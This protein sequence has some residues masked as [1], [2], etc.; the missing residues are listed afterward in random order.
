[1]DI[2]K[3]DILVIKVKYKILATNA[4]GIIAVFVNVPELS[5]MY[6]YNT[7]I[8]TPEL[9]EINTKL[10]IGSLMPKMM[11]ANDEYTVM[12]DTVSKM[13]DRLGM[14]L[15]GKLISTIIE[16]LEKKDTGSVEFHFQR[17]IGEILDE[18][19]MEISLSH[20]KI[21]KSIYEYLLTI[22][23]VEHLT[24]AKK[25]DIIS[26][27]ND[28]NKEASEKV[29]KN[30]LNDI[31]IIKLKMS[32]PKFKL[33]GIVYVSNPAKKIIS[34]D[35]AA[36]KK[37]LDNTSVRSS[38]IEL[39]NIIPE[40][41]EDDSKNIEEKI[42]EVLNSLIVDTIL[43]VVKAKSEEKLAALF[44]AAVSQISQ[45]VKVE[46][47]YE[48]QNSLF[49]HGLVEP[50][51]KNKDDKEDNPEKEKETMQ[52]V[53]VS[54]VLSP[55]KGKNISSLLPG[56]RINIML[57]PDNPAGRKLIDRLGLR[58]ENDKIHPLGVVVHKVKR[59]PKGGYTV[60]VKIGANLYGKTYEEEDIKIKCG[61]PVAEEQAK[62]SGKSLLIGLLAGIFV[63][64]ITVVFVIAII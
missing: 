51:Y 12:T 28:G 56:N 13:H 2:E 40:Y 27:F 5:M 41:H 54:L 20:E 63:I 19:K 46:A 64:I 33:L 44:K 38:F 39:K 7:L 62:Q 9:Y 18:D 15:D 17:I 10:K 37:P 22:E 31:L 49:L 52:T 1:M 24:Y 25:L 35:Y 8:S 6:N 42:K 23:N 36:S 4:S 32:D 30:N 57:D 29:L 61:D 11:H 43:S 53:E 3:K 14:I 16:N 48:V 55:T 59:E 45:T 26:N 21:T 50:K 47:S 58:D 60:Y 34:Y